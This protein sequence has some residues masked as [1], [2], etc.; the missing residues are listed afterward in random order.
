MP[1][2]VISTTNV[3][4]KA[5]YFDLLKYGVENNEEFSNYRDHGTS[6]VAKHK[7]SGAYITASNRGDGTVNIEVESTNRRLADRIKN[8]VNRSYS[9][10]SVQAAAKQKGWTLNRSG[11][12]SYTA[13]KA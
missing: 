8:S 11:Q 3:V 10:A 6:V 7:E 1:C 9:H 5:Q 13:V 2:Y 4:V 12:N